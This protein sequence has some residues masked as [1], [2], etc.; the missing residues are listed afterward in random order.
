M[1]C[2]TRMWGEAAHGHESGYR[3]HIHIYKNGILGIYMMGIVRGII[4]IIAS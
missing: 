4:I 1:V 3:G 2:V